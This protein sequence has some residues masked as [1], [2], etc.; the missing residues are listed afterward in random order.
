MSETAA[1]WLPV[2][3]VLQ[4]QKDSPQ[5]RFVIPEGRYP[6]GERDGDTKGCQNTDAAAE[7]MNF[8]RPRSSRAIVGVCQYLSPVSEI[9]ANLPNR[10]RVG[11][12]PTDVPG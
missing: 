11:W 9:F 2:R 4:L 10:S 1:L 12:Q 6:L 3:D 7:W 8:V 5:V